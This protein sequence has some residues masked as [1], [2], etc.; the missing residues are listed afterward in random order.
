MADLAKVVAQDPNGQGSLKRIEVTEDGERTHAVLDFDTAEAR[1]VRE[2]AKR[3]LLAPP[4]REE[5]EIAERPRR[6][7]MRLWQHNQDPNVAM[8]RQTGHQAIVSDIADR[9]KPLRYQSELA[10][11]RM[12]SILDGEPYQH[13]IFDVTI[14]PR[15]LE[16]KVKAYYLVE[17]HEWFEDD[18]PPPS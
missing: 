1:A 13:L 10:A 3:F 15:V 9:P 16:G 2:G 7:L 12:A 11:E 14:V 5:D 6:V 17:V 4:E 8:K 18:E